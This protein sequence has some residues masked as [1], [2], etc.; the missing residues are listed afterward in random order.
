MIQM[1]A[2]VMA[3][4]ITCVDE[5]DPYAPG[6]AGNSAGIGPTLTLLD[7]IP[8]KRLVLLSTAATPDQRAA[9]EAELQKL[10]PALA[11]EWIPVSLTDPQLSSRLAAQLARCGGDD[12]LTVCVNSGPDVVREVWPFVVKEAPATRWIA[13]HPAYGRATAGPVIV[14]DK[15]RAAAKARE[16]I[17]GYET[18]KLRLQAPDLATACRQLGLRGENPAFKNVL[19]MAA[20]LAPHQVP[21]LIHGE[22]GTGKGLL[23]ALI[24]EMSG[25]G[26]APFVAVNCAALPET[27]VESILFGHRKGSFTGAGAD[28]PGKFVVADGGTL[29]LDEVGELPLPLQ[30]KLLRV[31]EDGVVEPIGAIRG[32]PVNVRVVAAT[33]RDLKAAV[34]DKTFREDL[35]FRLGYAQLVL[36]P[37][38]AR[39]GDIK[40]LALYQLTLLNRSLAA[41]RRIDASA[42]KRLEEHTWPGNIRELA[43][44]IGRSVLLSDK[45]V[46]QGEDLMIDPLP[47]ARVEPSTLP[48]IGAGF[49]LETY[50]SDVRKALIRRAVEQAGG[51][52]SRAARLLGISPQAVHKHLRNG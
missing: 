8:A 33:H 44:V 20:R 18:D 22:T 4:L 10:Y 12:A 24:H 40:L 19:E 2:T 26:R 7:R 41:P 37:L 34:A 25:R 49:S 27:L 52:K 36:P 45:P 14:D 50:V 9:L 15:P 38:R 28:Q 43:N 17:L 23:A 6:L 48:E 39:R 31:L 1:Q 32:T 16:P 13:V 29:F 51:N 21:L 47:S 30:A 42:V 35:Y 5:W 11:V 3:I 46:L